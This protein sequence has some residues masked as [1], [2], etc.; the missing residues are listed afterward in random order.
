[1]SPRL[2]GDGEFELIRRAAAM[3]AVAAP[4][5]AKRSILIGSGDDAAVLEGGRTV[6]SDL[7]V[8]GVH[9]RRSWLDDRGTGFRACAAA[10]SDLAAM[11]ARPQAVTVSVALPQEGVDWD[12]L[13][14]GIAKAAARAGAAVVG[15]DLSRSPGPLVI[16]VTVLGVADRPVLRTGAET[17]DDLWVTGPLG[18]AAAA[19]SAWEAGELPPSEAISAFAHP[20]DRTGL[21]LSLAPN[22][23]V[24]AMI[25]LSDG[26]AADT[27]QLAAASQV[28]AV[29]DTSRVPVA[30]VAVETLGSERALELALH[31]GEDYELLFAAPPG[32]V[33]PGLARTWGGVFTKVGYVRAGEGVRLL[34][35]GAAEGPARLSPAPP[36]TGFN[37]FPIP[38]S[39]PSQVTGGRAGP[40]L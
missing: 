32:A 5:S 9:F 36:H 28:E 34:G 11:A 17:G 2:A 19:V 24:R 30:S 25:D 39:G 16:D 15:G 21:A 10:L 31:G 1:M 7:S 38:P 23:S 8:E 27:A 35:D 4:D 29:L 13:S 3:G 14:A 26:L 40:L 18:A 6:S 12:G 22:F 33:D 37:H 20:P